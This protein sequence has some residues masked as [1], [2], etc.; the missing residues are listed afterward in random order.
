MTTLNE[1]Q[2]IALLQESLPYDPRLFQQLIS[3][4]LPNL[5]GYCTKLLNNQ[6]DAEDAVQETIIKA[7]TH[8]KNFEWVVSFKAWLL[9]LLI[10]NV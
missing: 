2:L 10:M 8:L 5:K 3:P 9:K 6:S 1:R 7:L 4:Y